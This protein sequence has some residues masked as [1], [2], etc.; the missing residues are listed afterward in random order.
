MNIFSGWPCG[1]LVQREAALF[2]RTVGA[3]R[4]HQ[5]LDAHIGKG[6]A[7]HHVVVAAARAVAVEVGLLHAV[8]QQPLAG[9]RAFLDGT[10]GRNVV[11][12]DGVAKQR[13]DARAPHGHSIVGLRPAQNP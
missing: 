8:G 11:G 7:H 3:G 2:A 6:A 9:G 13:H 5:V 10:G 12:G 4:Q 1:W